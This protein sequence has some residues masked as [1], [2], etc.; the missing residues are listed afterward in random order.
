VATHDLEC[1]L[2]ELV[3]RLDAE[4]AASRSEAASA[5]AVILGS[6]EGR[7]PALRNRVGALLWREAPLEHLVAVAALPEQPGEVAEERI[8]LEVTSYIEAATRWVPLPEPEEDGQ[9]TPSP[10]VARNGQEALAELL[11]R[12]RP[13]LPRWVEL[14]VDSGDH[15]DRLAGV[16]TLAD[17]LGIEVE[18]EELGALAASAPDPLVRA[19]AVVLRGAQSGQ[20][21]DTSPLVRV[22]AAQSMARRA[23]KLDGRLKARLAAALPD[24]DPDVRGAVARALGKTRDP[25]A[26][27]PLLAAFERWPEPDVARAL[28]ELGEEAAA[29][30]L[31]A[32]LERSMVSDPVLAEAILVALA[33]TGGQ[34]QLDAVSSALDHPA[35]E[36]RRAAVAAARAIGG[37]RGMRL[38]EERR[39]D[40]AR[41]VREVATAGDPPDTRVEP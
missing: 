6:R 12:Y 34:T 1:E 40:F 31:A 13:R 30:P 41:I 17:E 25:V 14:F 32:A 3:T 20:L 7:D 24:R 33:Q 29:A 16:L 4:S 28:G 27:E 9:D 5:L 26:R 2:E 39:R 23:S 37:P 11:S 19:A 18:L 38:V 10:L 35:A 21:D 36:V 22:A 15:P 8:R